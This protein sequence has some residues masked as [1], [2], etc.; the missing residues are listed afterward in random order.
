MQNMPAQL[1][2][3]ESK[4]GLEEDLSENRNEFVEE[5]KHSIRTHII[6]MNGVSD[7]LCAYLLKLI[8]FMTDKDV[9]RRSKEI[10]A[11]SYS[12]AEAGALYVSGSID[13]YYEKYQ[14][15]GKSFPD[16]VKQNSDA[17]LVQIGIH[18]SSKDK[19]AAKNSVLKA[20]A[21]AL[22]SFGNFTNI[23]Y[24]QLVDTN[25]VPL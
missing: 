1:S 4:T 9:E 20:A 15:E 16:E 7:Q 12:I 22:N 13:S 8:D 23:Q 3:A 17:V 14:N 18:R 21:T 11:L 5:L 19:I 10:A 25:G 24:P 2:P 6:L